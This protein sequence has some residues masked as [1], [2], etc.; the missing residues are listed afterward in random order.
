M[1]YYGVEDGRNNY[2]SLIPLVDVRPEPL[3][4]LPTFDTIT[5]IVKDNTIEPIPGMDV[6]HVLDELDK[7]GM[8][9]MLLYLVY[10]WVDNEELDFTTKNKRSHFQHATVIL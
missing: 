4:E 7:V 10:R 5:T 9:S 3:K 6:S 8:L 2:E 1:S